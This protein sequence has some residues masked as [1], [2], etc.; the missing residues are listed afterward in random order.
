MDELV[1]DRAQTITAADVDAAKEALIRSRTTHL[2]A[3]G[4][5]LKEPRVA[6]VVQAVLLGD[7]EV[8]YDTDDF[9]YTV[10]LGLIVQAKSGAVIANPLYRE[11]LAR[12]LSYRVQSNL[13]QPWWPWSKPDGKLDVLALVC[14]FTEWWRENAAVLEERADKDYLEAVPHLVFMAFLQRVVN[15]GGR[16]TREYAAGRGAL[17]LLLECAGESTFSRSSECWRDTSPM[18]GSANGGSLR[19]RGTSTRPASPRGGC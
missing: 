4:Q 14:A 3:L 10:D 16:I 13:A 12:E 17:D 6:R 18:S 5:R 15:G 9:T 8:P 19:S 7:A 11:V 2:D 1:P